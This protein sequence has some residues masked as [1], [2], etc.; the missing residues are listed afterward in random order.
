[1]AGSVSTIKAEDLVLNGTQSLEQALQGK[2]PGVDYPK[3]RRIGR[4]PPESTSTGYLDVV[5]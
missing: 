3:P 2:L 4:Y 1:M 5:G